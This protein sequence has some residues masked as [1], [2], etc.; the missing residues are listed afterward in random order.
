MP[1]MPEDT[2]LRFPASKC[3]DQSG[4]L[5]KVVRNVTQ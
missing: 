5:R 4:F 3:F 2:V 1:Q